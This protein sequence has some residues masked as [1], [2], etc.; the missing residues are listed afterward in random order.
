M[1]DHRCL[2]WSSLECTVQNMKEAKLTRKSWTGRN[3]MPA[4]AAERALSLE[5]RQLCRSWQ[6]LWDLPFREVL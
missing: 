6:K 4:Q 3:V 2:L 5:Q 1:Q